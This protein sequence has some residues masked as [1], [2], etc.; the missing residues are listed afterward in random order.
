MADGLLFHASQGS[1]WLALQAD[2]EGGGLLR[3]LIQLGALALLFG[4]GI[5]RGILK[6]RGTGGVPPAPSPQRRAPRQEA[7]APPRAAPPEPA[8]TSADREG[9]YRSATSESASS[10][11]EAETEGRDLWKELLERAQEE[12]RS[13]PVRPRPQDPLAEPTVDP[14]RAARARAAERERRRPARRRLSSALPSAAS[15]APSESELEASGGD[16]VRPHAPLTQLQG[17][18]DS[19]Q[20]PGADAR[21]SGTD[22]SSAFDGSSLGLGSLGDPPGMPADA[23]S[24][25]GPLATDREALRRAVLMAEILGPPLALRPDAHEGPPSARL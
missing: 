25:G 13:E 23:P 24:A 22:L 20:L 2:D 8:S 17:L 4:P 6:E 21:A 12:E 15:T 10:A 3:M 14:R 16:R 5:L 7:P 19:A 9:E 1:V 18:G 11:S